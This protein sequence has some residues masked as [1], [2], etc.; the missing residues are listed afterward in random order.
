MWITYPHY[1]HFPHKYQELYVF[2]AIL[3]AKRKGYF[4]DSDTIII[5]DRQTPT[6][7]SY[8]QKLWITYPHFPQAVDSEIRGFAHT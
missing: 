4:C 1:P 8:P 2:L 3:E 7:E 6:K 5:I